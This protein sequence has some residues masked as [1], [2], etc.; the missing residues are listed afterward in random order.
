MESSYIN[1]REPWDL[2]GGGLRFFENCP[3]GLLREIEEETGIIAKIIEPFNVYDVIKSNIHLTIITYICEC[4]TYNVYLSSE[5]DAFYWL[6]LDEVR[7]SNIPKWL[8]RE[9]EAALKKLK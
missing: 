9:F 2:P 8:K 3:N 6:T 7:N 1:R 4:D 5:H